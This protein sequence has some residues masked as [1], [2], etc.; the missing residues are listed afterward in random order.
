VFQTLAA[1]HLY[2]TVIAV[3]YVHSVLR[4]T[5]S[6]KLSETRSIA[7]TLRKEYGLLFVPTAGKTMKENL[8]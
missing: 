5:R 7:A 4:G 2:S 1:N 8:S 3:G 6:L